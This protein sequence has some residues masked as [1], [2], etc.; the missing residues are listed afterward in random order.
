MSPNV[1]PSVR[2]AMASHAQEAAP[3][4]AVGLVVGTVGR[5]TEY[6]RLR[7]TSEA[8]ERSFTIDPLEFVRVEGAARDRGLR[9][10]GLFHAH[11]GGEP[12][13]SP[14]DCSQTWPG[15]WCWI[16]ALGSGGS[17]DLRAFPLDGCRIRP[18]AARDQNR[19]V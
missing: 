16:G 2:V 8:P 17:F 9:V 7:N 4:E 13:P 5:G 18:A 11:P 15:E 6:A 1:E 3:H 19:I 10:L 14:T 12:W